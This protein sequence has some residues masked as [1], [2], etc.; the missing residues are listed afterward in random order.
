MIPVTG[1]TLAGLF[2]GVVAIFLWTLLWTVVTPV[3]W[4]TQDAFYAT[5]FFGGGIATSASLLPEMLR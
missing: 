2:G 3:P 5:V 1:L 4:L